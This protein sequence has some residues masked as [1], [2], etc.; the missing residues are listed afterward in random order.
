MIAGAEIHTPCRTSSDTPAALVIRARIL[1]AH[2]PEPRLT[3]T[4][5]KLDVFERIKIR[6]I[7]Q[8]DRV[9]HFSFDQH[10]AAADRI[11]HMEAI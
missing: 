8:T 3:S 11:D 7:K 4:Q 9:E 2:R 5:A 6:F 1:H 10:G